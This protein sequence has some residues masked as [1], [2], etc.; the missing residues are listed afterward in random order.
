MTPFLTDAEVRALRD[1]T[2]SSSSWGRKIVQK[3]GWKGTSTASL[4]SMTT[5]AT[6]EGASEEP[7]DDDGDNLGGRMPPPPSLPVA[8]INEMKR[9]IASLRRKL[10]GAEARARGLEAVNAELKSR[11]ATLTNKINSGAGRGAGNDHVVIGSIFA[12]GCREEEDLFN[13][14]AGMGGVA[15]DAF[16]NAAAVEEVEGDVVP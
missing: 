10:H 8:R 14:A 15:A 5:S 2:G 13:E 3:F 16:T 7:D 12:S 4:S 1:F 6:A 11:L 9:E